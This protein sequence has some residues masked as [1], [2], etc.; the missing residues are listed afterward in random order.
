MYSVGIPAAQEAKALV[1][2]VNLSDRT[3]IS[4]LR[5]Q[6]TSL[7]IEVFFNGQLSSCWLM[8]IHD[9]RSGV[10]G[11]HQ[12][13]AGTRVDFLAERPWII[14]PPG[15]GPDGSP[16]AEHTPISVLQRW[17]DI[18]QALQSE[19]QERGCNKEGEV[20]PTATFLRALATMQMPDEVWNIQNPGGKVFGTIDV[21]ITAGDG[22]KLTSGV[23]YL[24]TP[25]RMLDENFPF[26]LQSD[27]VAGN[28]QPAEIG[29]TASDTVLYGFEPGHQVL[30]TETES[31]LHQAHNSRSKRRKIVSSSL[32]THEKSLSVGQLHI[33]LSPKCARQ[34]SH[35]LVPDDVQYMQVNH[36]QG[37]TVAPSGSRPKVFPVLHTPQVH[38]SFCSPFSY[39]TQRRDTSS[40]ISGRVFQEN[41]DPY[42]VSLKHPSSSFPGLEYLPSV[43]STKR[44]GVGWDQFGISDS[45]LPHSSR[46]QLF[47]FLTDV[48]ASHSEGCLPQA[49]SRVSKRPQQMTPALSSL[50]QVHGL[51]W[52]EATVSPLM[53]LPSPN[54]HLAWPAPPVGLFS[55]PTK[56][57]RSIRR[58][59]SPCSVQTKKDVCE[60]LLTKVVILGL[61]SV[62]LV[63]HRWDP[64]KRITVD[65]PASPKHRDNLPVSINERIGPMEHMDISTSIR[66]LCE[67]A[68]QMNT[69]P[70]TSS[71]G[72]STNV[73]LNGIRKGRQSQGEDMIS[74]A[75]SADHGQEAENLMS[76]SG[77]LLNQSKRAHIFA[78]KLES[79]RHTSLSNSILAVQSPQTKPY[80]FGRSKEM[81]CEV[82]TLSSLHTTPE[83]ETEQTK[84]ILPSKLA[85]PLSPVPMQPTGSSY[86]PKS[87]P[88]LGHIR[89]VS[90][91]EMPVLM[92][93]ATQHQVH[94]NHLSQSSTTRKRKAP[95]GSTAKRSRDR[96]CSKTN[97]NPLLNQG[98]VI[99]YAESKNE[100]EQDVLRQVRS[101]RLGTFREDYVVFASRFFVGEKR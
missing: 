32:V 35:P 20:P 80:F 15:L 58:G 56:P 98:C 2:H 46:E 85:G 22:K 63:E 92:T 4:G 55:V 76:D 59:K 18:C 23:G 67:G 61:D 5:N 57:K 28:L 86:P 95:H 43:L 53:S 29:Q 91:P 99:A 30:D 60:I 89:L 51:L 82:S 25:A 16:T 10:R 38:S 6:R 19:A 41:A 11:H 40:D 68:A 34:N 93:E 88:N 70:P 72:H 45:A 42:S 21:V 33:P 27:G 73:F 37:Y 69:L 84:Y 13:F 97:C 31:G 83:V 52:H 66:K 74:G 48:E 54:G 49:V 9:L 64:P 3:Y 75:K 81:L 39:P 14:L 78:A 71:L 36:V 90:N 26:R 65:R 47:Q 24:K 50:Q 77:H 1:L 44:T 7:K 96:T 100:N 62:I 12:V 8:S 79:G 17:Q 87:L 101:E 94:T